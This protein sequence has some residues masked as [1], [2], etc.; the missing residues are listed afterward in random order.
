MQS[1][2]SPYQV[3]YKDYIIENQ[4]IDFRRGGRGN[5]SRILKYDDNTEWVVLDDKIKERFCGFLHLQNAIKETNSCHLEAAENKMTIIEGT[6]VY[7]S[8][9]CGEERPTKTVIH[10]TNL[11]EKTGYVDFVCYANMREIG[12]KIYIFDTEKTSFD[13]SVHAKIDAYINVHDD[14]LAS[15]KKKLED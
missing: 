12:D 2:T 13:K 14:I 11:K 10:L 5:L 9:Y 6:I 7:L 4:P 15:L 3:D 8:K 1:I